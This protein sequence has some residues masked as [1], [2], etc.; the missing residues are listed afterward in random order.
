V[1]RVTLARMPDMAATSERWAIVVP[2]KRLAVAKT[3]IELDP[4]LRMELALAMAT[5][6]IRAAAECALVEVVVAVCDDSDAA[7]ALREAGAVVVPDKPDAG[8]NPA[9]VHGASVRAVP[10]E[11]GI[12]AVAADLP[13]LRADELGELLRLAA[14]AP[15]TVVADASGAGTTVFAAADRSGFRPI[16]GPNSRSRHLAAGAVDLT[17]K[18]GATVRRDVDT[19]A[20]LADAAFLGLGPAT[21]QVV[22]AHGLG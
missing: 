15:M 3:R 21:K 13:A 17:D 2:V 20:D 14:D 7:V 5:D 16:F 18:A 8:L 11:G 4:D 10:A 22:A 9:L 6:T 12:A 19:L 1:R